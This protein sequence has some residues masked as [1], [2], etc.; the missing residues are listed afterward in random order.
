M[1]ICAGDTFSIVDCDDFTTGVD[2]SS[3]SDPVDRFLPAWSSVQVPIRSL[4]E[5]ER[6]LG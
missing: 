3:P 2:R 1:K 5:Y 4:D 6:V